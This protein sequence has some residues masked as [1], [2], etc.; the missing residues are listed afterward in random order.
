MSISAGSASEVTALYSRRTRSVVAGLTINPVEGGRQGQM[1]L[2]L[3]RYVISIEPYSA[4]G[5]LV[6]R[7]EHSLGRVP[8]ETVSHR[9]HLEREFGTLRIGDPVMG[10]T[11]ST[12]RTVLRM[13]GRAE[14]FSFPQRYVLG[15]HPILLDAG[16]S[17]S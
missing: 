17:W 16:G 12:A 11:D 2:W 13:E 9:P 8:M 5:W 15:D 4:G 14:F 1:V 10:L 3:D 7:Q 6:H